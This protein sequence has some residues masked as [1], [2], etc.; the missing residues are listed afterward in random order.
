MLSKI[1]TVALLWGKYF[2]CFSPKLS[3]NMVSVGREAR[4][5]N[6]ASQLKIDLKEKIKEV[7]EQTGKGVLK[8]GHIYQ[9][10]LSTLHPALANSPQSRNAPG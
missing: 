9:T 6:E 2:E 3:I 10:Q 1:F 4:H 8:P 7:I 5:E